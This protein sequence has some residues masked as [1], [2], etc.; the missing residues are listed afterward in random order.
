MVTKQFL[1]ILKILF[2]YHMIDIIF[3]IVRLRFF[4][5]EN[6]QNI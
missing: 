5:I 1:K 6:I 2:E 3:N 4:K